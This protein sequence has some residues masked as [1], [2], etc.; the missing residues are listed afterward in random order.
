[1]IHIHFIYH[2]YL[3]QEVAAVIFSILYLLICWS[4]LP[5]NVSPFAVFD[6]V[7][8]RFYI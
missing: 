5:L 3:P 8:A 7:L 1:M 2:I 6:D 4:V